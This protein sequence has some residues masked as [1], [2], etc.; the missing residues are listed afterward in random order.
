MKSN[1]FNL[2]PGTIL[3][4]MFIRN[5]LKNNSVEEKTFL[6]IGSGS[7]QISNILLSLG[8]KGIGFDLSPKACSQNENINKE[9]ILSNR[10]EIM[11]NDFFSYEP[12]RKVDY[13][14][15]SQVIEHFD[16]AMVTKYFEKCCSILSQG[17][18]IITLVPAGMKYWGIEDITV[19]HYKR[20]SFEDFVRISHSFNLEINKNCGLTFPISNFLLPVSNFLVSRAE[21]WKKNISMQRRT[22]LSSSGG[23]RHIVGKTKFPPFF[24]YILNEV[25][26]YPLYLLQIL[27]TRSSRSMVIF[28]ELQKK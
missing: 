11:N 1:F 2:P 16:D 24:K 13:I 6:E 20:Y 10:Y 21:N 4:S 14:I 12:D 17:G 25:T 3:Q 8:M 15:S 19:G 22:E 26:M 7:G 28:C 9:Y 18:K 27:F 23:A 5:Y